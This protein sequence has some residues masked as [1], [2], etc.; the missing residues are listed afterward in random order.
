LSK[1]YE[2]IIYAPV[3]QKDHIGRYQKML[4]LPGTKPD[5]GEELILNHYREHGCNALIMVGDMWPVVRSDLP[6]L[7]AAEEVYW[8]QWGAVDYL[9][10]W[11]NFILEGLRYCHKIV[12]FSQW[13]EGKLREYGFTNVAPAI[14]PGLDTKLWKPYPRNNFPK[15]ASSLGFEEDSFRILIVAAN[16][17]RKNF[18]E[19]FE[20]IRLFRQKN[21]EVK[22]KLYVHSTIKG[23]RNL[24]DDLHYFQLADMTRIAD[25]YTVACGAYSE[26]HMVMMFASADVVVAAALEGYGFATV[27]AQAVGV[28]VI[29]LNEGA[30]QELTHGGILIPPK[31]WSM[32]ISNI[33]KAVPN[34][35]A[36]ATGLEEIWRRGP[37]RARWSKGA[38]WVAANLDWE[39]HVA[40]QWYQLLDRCF[41]EKKRQCW[42]VPEPSKRL[43]KQARAIVEVV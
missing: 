1:R 29:T 41:E 2:V 30:S 16:Q 24:I 33:K 19:H 32:E 11:P 9:P 34:E 14:W 12:P 26:E 21:P 13:G 6:K 23:D 37:D 4:V 40:P 8:I 7:A 20:G 36:I 3:Y 28:P 35:M 15:V 43:N 27:Q 25:E 22:I 17:G 42:S 38:E 10:P 31:D 18:P 39:R 5:Y